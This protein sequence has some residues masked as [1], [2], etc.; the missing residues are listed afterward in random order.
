MIKKFVLSSKEFYQLI[1]SPNFS[2]DIFHQKCMHN[3][4]P[5]GLITV[6]WMDISNTLHK[7]DIQVMLKG[8]IICQWVR[9]DTEIPWIHH[10][11][12]FSP[13]LVIPPPRFSIVRDHNKL[14]SLV[15]PGMAVIG[16]LRT[17]PVQSK[18]ILR[19]ELLL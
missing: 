17:S 5:L 15:L 10:T 16:D 9:C 12:Q 1:I 13:P 3:S 4:K 6:W 19:E 14:H 7:K 11:Q 18:F 8:S 2:C